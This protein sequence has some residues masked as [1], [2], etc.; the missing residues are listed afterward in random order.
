MF[1]DIL[2]NFEPYVFCLQTHHC[3]LNNHVREAAKITGDQKLLGKLSI[4][5]MVASDAVYHLSCL[6][7]LYKRAKTTSAKTESQDGVTLQ[8]E[9]AFEDLINHLDELKESGKP[10]PMKNLTAYYDQVLKSRSGTHINIH[11]TRLRQ[12]IL[13]RMPQLK[14]VE[15]SSG[16]HLVFDEHVAHLNAS[17]GEIDLLSKAAEMIRRE[18]LSKK[19]S[20]TA[21]F[22]D[23]SEKDSV[24]ELLLV[25]LEMLLDG[26]RNT[27]SSDYS[28]IVLSLA[29]LIMFNCVEKR[30]AER[31]ENLDTI[32]QERR[33]LL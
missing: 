13:K 28:K 15:L 2:Y 11:T 33:H 10:I 1:S 5:D 23:S 20:V 22:T 4:A 18:I 7:M 31:A 27:S 19:Q 12:E 3:L 21:S 29:Q 8:R 14:A 24:V 6:S 17:S 16:W 30:T 25:F 32:K 9:E 26:E